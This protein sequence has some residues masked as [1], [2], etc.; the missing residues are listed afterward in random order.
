M[1]MPLHDEDPDG[2]AASALLARAQAIAAGSV[3]SPAPG[4]C[5]QAAGGLHVPALPSVFAFRPDAGRGTAG[6]EP[7]PLSNGRRS[8]PG[9]WPLMTA[10]A[11][12]AGA[13]LV[14]VPLL[15]NGPREVTDMAGGDRAVPIATFASDDGDGHVSSV[16]PDGSAG[17]VAERWTLGAASPRA[18]GP[19]GGS[20]AATRPSVAR[21]SAAAAG[22]NTPAAADGRVGGDTAASPT[23]Y[24]DDG[25][26]SVPS[27]QG[28][29]GWWR[30]EPG[31]TLP[32]LADWLPTVPADTQTPADPSKPTGHAQR[33]TGALDTPQ[34][35]PRGVPRITLPKLEPKPDYIAKPRTQAYTPATAVT[36]TPTTA[37]AASTPADT[38]KG[39]DASATTVGTASTPVK[40]PVSDATPQAAAKPTASPAAGST[41]DGSVTVKQNTSAQGTASAPAKAPAQGTASTPTATGATHA[42]AAEPAKTPAPTPEQWRTKVLRGGYELK[43]GD[44]V[45]TNRVRLTLRWGGNLIIS[46]RHGAIVWSSHTEGAG[47]RAVFQ[48]D[49]NLVVYRADGKALW[50][51]RT[52]H[53]PGA[54]LVLQNDGNV[55]ILSSSDAVLWA[56][57]T[58]D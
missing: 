46:D 2:L 36:Q 39:Q 1:A 7:G 19:H 50:S 12:V 40:S 24:A 32:S 18:A 54:K 33:D 52:G 49:G 30:T 34:G 44:F 4:E 47:N 37:A 58:N 27:D 26:A 5:G 6:E 21:G 25:L 22:A 17:P 57:G 56:A 20:S 42:P 43:A 29:D 14:S 13:V 51:T 10:A 16:V 23:P 41:S 28:R 48:A 8:V 9:S 31:T 11:A 55:T 38:T 15:H 35:S 3:V 45:E 53:N